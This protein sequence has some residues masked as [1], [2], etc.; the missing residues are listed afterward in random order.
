MIEFSIGFILGIILMFF[1][2][3]YSQMKKEIAKIKKGQT[4]TEEKVL[5]AKNA[6][7]KIK[8]LLK[9]IGT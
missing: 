4:E 7:R 3:R 2:F 8:E 1:I 5:D 6:I 9:E